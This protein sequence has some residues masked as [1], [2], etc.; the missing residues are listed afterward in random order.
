MVGKTF[1]NEGEEKMVWFNYI[2]FTFLV[3]YV[4]LWLGGNFKY[5]VRREL[6][7]HANYDHTHIINHL[8]KRAREGWLL[9]KMNAFGYSFRRIAPQEVRFAIAYGQ[10]VEIDSPDWRLL[11]AGKDIEIF[12]SV[13][14]NP[15]PLPRN[16]LEDVEALHKAFFSFLKVAFPIWLW[17]LLICVGGLA[18][19][20]RCGSGINRPICFVHYWCGNRPTD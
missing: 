2:F 9:E 15:S 17:F 14:E 7:F 5:G 4:L 8:E 20:G 13:Q 11:I 19:F 6:D 10:Q 16:R 1:Y 18:I 3:G 12:A